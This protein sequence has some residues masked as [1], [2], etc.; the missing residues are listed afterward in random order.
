MSKPPVRILQ[1]LMD[2]G[3]GGGV[4]NVVL[5]W[6]RNIDRALVQ[7][8]YL[9]CLDSGENFS[10]EIKSLGGNLYKM[11]Y[12]GIFRPVT[13]IK[14]VNDFFKNHKYNTIHSHVTQL[15][16]FYFPIAKA[17]GVKN[18]I[19]HSHGTKWSDKI[20]NGARNYLMLSAARP[21]VTHKLACSDASGKVW[22]GKGYKVIFNGTEL[23]KFAF[24]PEVRRRAREELGLKEQLVILHGGR[25]SAEKNHAFLIDV[26]NRVHKKNKDA[27]LLL[28][29]KGPLEERIKLKVKKLGLGN[30]VRFL[31]L[32]RDMENI[33]QAADIFLLP[34]FHEG[35]PVTALEAQAAGLCCFLSDKVTR[36]A[37]VFN[38]VFLP[39][40][41]ADLWAEEILRG[42]PADRK[43]G[44]ET[45][46]ACGLGNGEIIKKITS[47][48][49]DLEC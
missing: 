26:F 19:L 10:D 4:A 1:I 7:F 46:E 47:F 48:Y 49:S 23:A 6:H 8:D 11:P 22:H 41:D 25:F 5:N 45:L 21:F 17:R 32:R 12:H 9:Y 24:N 28:A 38:T 3:R 33:Y 43:K 13:F 36:E 37:G 39:V 20:L 34:S 2:I 44:V 29:G 35:F 14:A 40:A 16:F 31:G 15:N 30:S 18:I 27:V 42:K